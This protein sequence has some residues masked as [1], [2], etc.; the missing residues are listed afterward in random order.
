MTMA[1]NT[2]TK[3]KTTKLFTIVA[4]HSEEPRRKREHAN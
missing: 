1:V 4:L 3:V 2:K